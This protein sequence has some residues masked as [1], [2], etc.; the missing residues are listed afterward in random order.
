VA[1]AGEALDEIR[2]TPL[3]EPLRALLDPALVRALAEAGAARGDRDARL[4]P[5]LDEGE[6]RA[7]RWLEACRAR[8]GTAGAADEAARA[9]RAAWAEAAVQPAAARR[10]DV[11]T[12][13]GA[14]PI[15]ALA[16]AGDGTQPAASAGEASSDLVAFG[17][18]L[19]SAAA[20][21][22]AH[23]DPGPRARAA[24]AERWGAWR[25]ARQVAGALAGLGASGA[26]AGRLSRM[27]AALLRHAD[28][29][30]ARDA[31]AGRA[32]VIV[33][34]WLAD[35]DVRAVL[36]LHEH[37]GTWWIR[38]EAW[39]EWL[40]AT[41]WGWRESLTA[42]GSWA[43]RAAPAAPPAP[44]AGPAAPRTGAPVLR[45]LDAEEARAGLDATLRRL[46]AL[47]EA[48][49]W[50]A[51]DLVRRALRDLAPASPDALRR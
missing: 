49:G 43:S 4:R 20:G 9:L 27:P 36:D 18:R 29:G 17:V 19:A 47:G 37:G 32:G 35:P 13:S 15:D 21:A 3:N 1:D 30:S 51:D 23:L 41:G 45:A 48:S 39:S 11:A 12:G 22:L 33:E 28:E 16:P 2:L 24:A 25:C 5:W 42:A 46:E 8:A 40:D 14:A 7:R 26:H 50:D 34:R 31:V 10:S 6:S 44:T 38:A